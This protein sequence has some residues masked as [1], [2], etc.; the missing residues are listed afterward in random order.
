M[1]LYLIIITNYLII[2]SH[3][4]FTMSNFS[5]TIQ[6]ELRNRLIFLSYYLGK[7][8]QKVYSK[9][10]L[11]G[12]DTVVSKFHYRSQYS[13]TGKDLGLKIISIKEDK[14][15]KYQANQHIDYVGFFENYMLMDNFSF[16]VV[17]V[18]LGSY[19][20]FLPFSYKFDDYSHSIIHNYK[21]KGIINKLAFYL[22]PNDDDSKGEIQI[23]ENKNIENSK[24][25]GFCSPEKNQTNWGCFYTGLKIEKDEIIDPSFVVFSTT[26]NRLIVPE[27]VLDAIVN[28]I[29]PLYFDKGMCTY[30][31]YPLPPLRKYVDC[32]CNQINETFPNITIIINNYNFVLTY[33]ELF[34]SFYNACTFIFELDT[35]YQEKYVFGI[36]FLLKYTTKFDYESNTISFYSD[37]KVIYQNNSKLNQITIIV[38]ISFLFVGIITMIKYFKLLII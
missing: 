2:C 14:D 29:F 34:R 33:K 38:C 28:K 36:D 15:W 16:C 32:H 11:E 31:K 25:F 10:A 23:G 26:E 4:E 7:P 13:E 12:Q 37:D 1:L 22:S 6:Y 19:V 5:L 20:P 21:S 27:N 24:Y 8:S 30:T 18:D 17:D 35:K 9:L 3:E